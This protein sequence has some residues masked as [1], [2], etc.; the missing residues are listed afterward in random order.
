M[1]DFLKSNTCMVEVVVQILYHCNHAL[2]HIHTYDVKVAVGNKSGIS[3]WVRTG[4]VPNGLLEVGV[5]SW[6]WG[7]LSMPYAITH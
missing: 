3:Q 4:G 2:Q 6:W 1:N 5:V 7:G